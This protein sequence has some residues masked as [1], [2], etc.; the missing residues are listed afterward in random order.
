MK[1]SS[2]LTGTITLVSACL[3]SAQPVAQARSF[4][5]SG[6][7][8]DIHCEINPTTV[9]DNGYQLEVYL[10][11][12]GR[13][14]IRGWTV[15]LEFSEP[16]QITASWNSQVAEI[17]AGTVSGSNVA[18]N[19]ELLPGQTT[20]FGLQGMHDGSFDLPGCSVR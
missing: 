14:V 12:T 15:I 2:K 18:W 8:R 9:S 7:N 20:S 6:N 4:T 3:L 1:P 19:G 16:A 5:P 13:S 17:S 10:T 11:N